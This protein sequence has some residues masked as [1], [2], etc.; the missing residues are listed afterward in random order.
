MCCGKINHFR[1]ALANIDHIGSAVVQTLRKRCNQL[2]SSSANIAAN[3][4]FFSP[5][6]YR[7]N[8]SDKVGHFLVNFRR[9]NTPDIVSF[10]SISVQHENFSFSEC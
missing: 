6:N 2:L 3:H 1:A 4:N 7:K 5:I 10:K 9:H 8:S